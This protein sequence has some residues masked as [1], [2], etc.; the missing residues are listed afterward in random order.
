MQ[1]GRPTHSNPIPA[2]ASG[3]QFS[4]AGASPVEE[5][6]AS[7][8]EE[9]KEPSSAQIGFRRPPYQHSIGRSEYEGLGVSGGAEAIAL[10]QSGQFRADTPGVVGRPVGSPYSN[11]PSPDSLRPIARLK[12]KSSQSTHKNH[13][14]LLDDSQSVNKKEVMEI[15]GYEVYIKDKTKG[16]I[17]AERRRVLCEKEDNIAPKMTL[18]IRGNSGPP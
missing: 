17:K 2:I 15:E 11:K 18:D 13:H 16:G 6:R 9:P 10:P 14:A 5:G 3:G 7:R 12:A 1:I 8:K 4:L